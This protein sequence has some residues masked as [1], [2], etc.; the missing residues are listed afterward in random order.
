MNQTGRRVVFAVSA[1][2]LAWTFGQAFGLLPP[3]GAGIRPYPDLLNQITVP[4]RHATDVVTAVNFDYRGL[5]TL[6]EETI[7]FASIVGVLLLLRI[8][9]DERKGGGHDAVPGRH[10]PP[11]SDAVRVTGLLLIGPLLLFGLDIMT[12]GQLTPGGGFQGGVIVATAVVLIYLSG[13]VRLFE[14]VARETATRTIEA[15]GLVTFTAVG[16]VGAVTG[17]AYLQNVLPLGRIGSV[18]SSGTIAVLSIATGLAVTGGFLALF[19]CFL[20]QTLELKGGGRPS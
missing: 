5:D 3:I 6:G 20:Q 13:N 1:A 7:L 12:H 14:W 2:I 11:V 8:Q 19:T 16:A 15:I 18:L 10:V 9:A 17:G 4:A